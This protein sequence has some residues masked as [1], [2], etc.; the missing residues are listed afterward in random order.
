MPVIT[1]PVKHYQTKLITQFKVDTD[2]KDTPLTDIAYQAAC[3]LGFS[4]YL[5]I[6]NQLCFYNDIGSEFKRGLRVRS[7]GEFKEDGKYILALVNKDE[8]D[9][10][11]EPS[12]DNYGVYQ[13]KEI[14]HQKTALREEYSDSEDW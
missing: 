12:D 3:Q 4:S 2:D 14:Y 7:T 11:D 10:P 13:N 6:K 9:L 8:V 5:K 1:V